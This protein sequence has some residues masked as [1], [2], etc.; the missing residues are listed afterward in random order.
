M[1]KKQL[2]LALAGVLVCFLPVIIPLIP[3]LR[4]YA[5]AE[6]LKATEGLERSRIEERAKTSN[7]LYEAGVMPT[8]RK[9]R[10]TNYFDSSKRN[11][12]PDTTLYLDDE[13]IDVFDAT[14]RCIGRIEEGIWKWKHK[15]KEI[16]IS[17]QNIKQS[18]RK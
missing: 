3:K 6:R 16:C 1:Y 15:D 17:V 13:I 10:I 11:P 12:R 14:G 18:R 9:L 2:Y 4:A 5:E 8:T 7:A